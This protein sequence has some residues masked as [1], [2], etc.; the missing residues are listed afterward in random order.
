MDLVPQ[1][2]FGSASTF[3]KP[4]AHGNGVGK[5]IKLDLKT[6]LK[7]VN[8]RVSVLALDISEL[9]IFRARTKTKGPRKRTR[10]DLSQTSTTGDPMYLMVLFIFLEQY[11]YCVLR[12]FELVETSV[13]H[14]S[15]TCY[16]FGNTI[17]IQ[18]GS[19]K[20]F[21]PIVF[22]GLLKQLFISDC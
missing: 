9:S 7:H 5:Y 6:A 15:S 3:P 4:T 22:Y 10:L 17:E 1:L 18:I 2:K 12:L 8:E 11:K 14:S 21:W 19:K 20:R 16:V 13:S